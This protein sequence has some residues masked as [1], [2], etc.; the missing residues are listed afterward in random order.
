MPTIYSH[1]RAVEVGTFMADCDVG[2]MFLKFMLESAIRSHADFYLS[3]L[4]SDEENG[5]LTAYWE[6]MLMDFGPSPY[7]VIKDIMMVIE[8]AVRGL[9][10]DIKNVFRWLNVV[11]NFPGIISYDPSRPWVYCLREDRSLA[12][13]IFWYVDDGRPTAAKTWEG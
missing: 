1:L 6:R 8:E 11:L 7:F 2:E 9:R 3:K 12:V 13:D 5:M 10:S 4:L